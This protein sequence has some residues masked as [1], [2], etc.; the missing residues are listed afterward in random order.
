MK[1]TYLFC[2]DCLFIKKV[3]YIRNIT[4]YILF[5]GYLWSRIGNQAVTFQLNYMK[6]TCMYIDDKT[7]HA[8]IFLSQKK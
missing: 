2:I 4:S 3:I 1:H 8:Y 5:F 6:I 7:L